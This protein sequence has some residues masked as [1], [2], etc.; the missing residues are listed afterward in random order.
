MDY[1]ILKEILKKTNVKPQMICWTLLL[2]EFE[3]QIVQRKEEQPKPPEQETDI[4]IFI[5]QGII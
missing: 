4:A 3:L 2:Q 5:P 1:N